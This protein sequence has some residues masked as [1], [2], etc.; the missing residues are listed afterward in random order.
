MHPCQEVFKKRAGEDRRRHSLHETDTAADGSV[1]AAKKYG[2]MHTFV[3]D[4]GQR[5]LSGYRRIG[6]S[7]LFVKL[8]I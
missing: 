7:V 6:L 8:V 2:R 5:I 1:C 4:F 3:V